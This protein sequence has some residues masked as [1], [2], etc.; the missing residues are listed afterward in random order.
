MIQAETEAISSA[1]AHRHAG[2]ARAPFVL[3][4]AIVALQ[5]LDV[6]TTLAV[7]SAGGRETNPAVSVL[8][9]LLGPV[10]WVPKVIIASCIAGYFGTRPTVRWTGLL[11]LIL[12]ALVV[13]NNIAQLRGS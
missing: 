7:V 11:V 2:Q 4:A 8:M 3:G 6:L 10:W 13:L 9:A 1:G 12:G 5:M